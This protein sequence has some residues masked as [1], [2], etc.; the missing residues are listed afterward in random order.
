MSVFSPLDP[1]GPDQRRKQLDRQARQQAGAAHAA[2]TRTRTDAGPSRARSPWAEGRAFHGA[3]DVASAARRSVT[4]APN[5]LAVRPR[6]PRRRRQVAR[7]GDV[8]RTRASHRAAGP[9]TGMPIPPAGAIPIPT[10]G[11]PHPHL[12]RVA[13]LSARRKRPHESANRAA[14]VDANVIHGSVARRTSSTPASSRRVAA[15][16]RSATGSTTTRHRHGPRTAGR[17]PL[18][19]ALAAAGLG[20]KEVA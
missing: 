2:S 15:R 10:P 4:Q 1:R 6:T 17:Q 8:R 13:A 14:G 9:Q 12:M 11:L 7:R 5:I 19:H 16:S 3:G 18:A 20:S